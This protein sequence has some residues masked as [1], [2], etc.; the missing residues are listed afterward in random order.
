MEQLREIFG[1][2][3]F[4][5]PHPQHYGWTRCSSRSFPTNMIPWFRGLHTKHKQDLSIDIFG[6]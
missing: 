6:V 1:V 4:R 2:Q 3:A 5:N